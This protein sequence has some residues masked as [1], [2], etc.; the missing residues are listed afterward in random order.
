MGYFPVRYDSRVVIYERKMIIRLATGF[1]FYIKVDI[2]TYKGTYAIVFLPLPVPGLSTAPNP[3][4]AKELY[5]SGHQ[6]L[7]NCFITERSVPGIL[8]F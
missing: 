5:T 7:L 8:R 3:I 1:I 6:G 2:C 4:E